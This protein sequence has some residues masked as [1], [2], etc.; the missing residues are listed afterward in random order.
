M[1]LATYASVS[2][3]GTLIVVKFAAWVLTD[4]VSLLSTLIDSLLDAAAS[5]VNLFAVRHALAPPDREHRFGHGKAE[6]LAALG[7]STF[8]AGSALF[9]VI[10]AGQRLYEPQPVQRGEVGI[11]VMVFAIVVT[12]ALTRFQAHV[13][14]RTGSVAIRADSLH[15]VGDLLVNA[16]VI[17]ALVLSAQLGWIYADPLFGIAI[18][19]YILRTAWIIARGAMDML[20]DRELPDAERERIKQIVLAHREVTALHDLRTRV[21]GP[22]IFIQVHI[23]MD[24]DMSLYRAHEI[25]DTVEAA[26]RAAYPDAEVIIHQDPAGLEQVPA[27]FA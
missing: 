24:G 2:V 19:A 18:A 1:R 5:L 7:Q 3:A 22:R 26:L 13:V 11:G 4:S 9:L 8:I 27:Q 15:Y 23:E 17:V 21:S 10:E 12:F 20:M 25:A 6:P 16:A 14:R